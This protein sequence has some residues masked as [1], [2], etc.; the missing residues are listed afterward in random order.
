MFFLPNNPNS[1]WKINGT[2]RYLIMVQWKRNPFLFMTSIFCSDQPRAVKN[3][4]G[5]SRIKIKN[6]RTSTLLHPQ[7]FG[8][9]NP[10]ETKIWAVFG[11]MMTHGRLAEQK[12]VSFERNQPVSTTPPKTNSS[13]LKNDT[14][15]TTF[16][17]KWSLFSDMLILGGVLQLPKTWPQ[18]TTLKKKS[19]W[20]DK[21]SSQTFGHQV[22]YATP[23]FRFHFMKSQL[24][25]TLLF[26]PQS[27]FSGES[28]PPRCPLQ[29]CNFHPFSTCMIMRGR[30]TEGIVPC[31]AMAIFF[32]STS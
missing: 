18:L 14:S 8:Q 2:R 9:R 17:L 23:F 28:V 32:D 30:V 27:W 11:K 1:C 24:F 16:L 10:S 19:E 6:Y 20:N 3:F 15:K 13:L 12:Y 4:R 31:F 7:S 22:M 21:L 26:L 29:E 25:K 5:R